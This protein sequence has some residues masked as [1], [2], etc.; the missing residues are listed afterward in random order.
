MISCKSDGRNIVSVISSVIIY[1]IADSEF[2]LM[3]IKPTWV[4]TQVI[5][6]IEIA[7]TGQNSRRAKHFSSLGTSTSK[8]SRLLLVLIDRLLH[9]DI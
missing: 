1:L 3:N 4:D 8:S 7:V 9:G 5:L 2:A 6:D